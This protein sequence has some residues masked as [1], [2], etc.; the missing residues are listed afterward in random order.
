VTPAFAILNPGYGRLPDG[1]LPSQNLDWTIGCS[2]QFYLFGGEFVPAIR[3]TSC[4]APF[5]LAIFVVIPPCSKEQM[6]WVNA[7]RV[8]TGVKYIKTDWYLAFMYFIGNFMSSKKFRMFLAIDFNGYKAIIKFIFSTLRWPFHAVLFIWGYFG[9]KCKK[10]LFKR[11]LFGCVLA[12]G[13]ITQMPHVTP[14]AKP[15]TYNDDHTTFFAR[16][17]DASMLGYW[18]IPAKIVMQG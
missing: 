7:W 11:A 8:V 12:E 3:F 5:L 15:S 6:Q 14:T 2:N 10:S 4:I 16:H 9:I 1:K 17:A 13:P 18:Y